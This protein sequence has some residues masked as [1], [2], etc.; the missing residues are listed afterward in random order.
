LY[1]LEQVIKKCFS[2]VV[3]LTSHAKDSDIAR[4]NIPA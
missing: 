3:G 4:D 1:S 2:I